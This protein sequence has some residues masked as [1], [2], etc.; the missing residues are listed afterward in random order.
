MYLALCSLILAAGLLLLFLPGR[1][2]PEGSGGKGLLLFLRLLGLALAGAA[3][4][5]IRAAV[6][7]RLGPPLW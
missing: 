2:A 3:G 1:F 7:E 5:F 4:L 6:L